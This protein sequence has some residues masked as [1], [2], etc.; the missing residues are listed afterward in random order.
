MSISPVILEQY[1]QGW[2]ERS[3][4]VAAEQVERRRRAWQAA[5]QAAQVL[6]E[7]FGVERVRVFGSLLDEARFDRF[8]D[9][10]LAV[11][12]LSGKRYFAAV[13][14]L[15][16]LSAEFSVDLAAFEQASPSLQEVILQEGQDV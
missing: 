15:Q 11:W 3:R 2:R 13:G 16:G 12:G 14:R 1:R 5:R 4:T 9:I 7:Q 10:D 8:S 6:R